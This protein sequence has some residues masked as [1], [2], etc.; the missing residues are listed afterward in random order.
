[1]LIAVEFVFLLTETANE[2]LLSASKWEL[3]PVLGLRIERNNIKKELNK[4]EVTHFYTKFK[5]IF[6]K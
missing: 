2:C 5:I 1:M 6:K 4:S 3:T